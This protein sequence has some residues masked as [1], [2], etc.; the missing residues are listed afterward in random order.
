MFSFFDYFG[1]LKYTFAN[2]PHLGALSPMHVMLFHVLERWQTPFAH[3][4]RG[5]RVFPQFIIAS[6]K[7]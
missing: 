5:K 7:F 1:V 6:Y 3:F 2:L 4:F